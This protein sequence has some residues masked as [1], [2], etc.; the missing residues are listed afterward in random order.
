MG[1]NAPQRYLRLRALLAGGLVLGLGGAVTLAAWTDQENA[2]GSFTTSAF[3][4]ESNVTS[5]F[6]A[7]GSWV[8]DS[9]ATGSTLGFVAGGMSPGSIRYAPIALRTVAGS[10]GGTVLLSG[11]TVTSD[12]TGTADLGAA[13]RYRVVVSA[14]CDATAFNAEARFVVG[15]AS[16][17]QPLTT[18]QTTT[19]VS[20]APASS[21]LPGA[22]TQFC[23]QVQLPVGVSNDLQG[24][25]S[26]ALWR[27]NSTSAE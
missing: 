25:S 2:T 19:A 15:D 17:F 18:A 27:F 5:P 9:P 11:A 23:F 22:P 6:N 1:T 20:L 12:G 26:S 10:V 4:V 24:R 7:G 14:T 13:L 8:L 21:S 3:R 16:T